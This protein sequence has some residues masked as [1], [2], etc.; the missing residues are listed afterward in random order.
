MPIVIQITDDE[1]FVYRPELELEKTMKMGISNIKDIIAFG[2]NPEKTFIFSDVEYI[3]YLYP[4]V[5]RVQKNITLNQIKGIFGFDETANVGKFAFPPVQAVPAFSNSFPH[6]F[7]N[8]KN[9]PCLIPCAID[10]DPY[11]RMTR[12][13]AQ[14]L[15]YQK[16]CSIYSSFFPALQGL[17]SKMSSSD[18]NSS[19]LLTDK[20]DQI[21]FKINRYAYSGGQETAEL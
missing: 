8:R 7:G 4:N 17:K 1:K 5:L 11:F 18:P 6:I 13:I 3:Q 19:I 9:V 14:K 12:D 21:K 20:P 16:P 10:Q 2:F 15:K